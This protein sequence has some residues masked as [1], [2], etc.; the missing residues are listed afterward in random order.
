MSLEITPTDAT[1]AA[2][3]RGVD[4]SDLGVNE[5]RSIRVSTPTNAGGS[6]IKAS[7]RIVGVRTSTVPTAAMV[8]D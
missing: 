4:L 7:F 8:F 5:V 6:D 2:T 3:V 1:L